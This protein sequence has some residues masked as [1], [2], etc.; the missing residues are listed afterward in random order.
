MGELTEQ[1]LPRDVGSTGAHGEWPIS[2]W[3]M[4]AR[5]AGTAESIVALIPERRATD[6]GVLVRTMLESMVTFAWIGIDSASHA[7]ARLR[8]D[9][10]Q[11]LK[12]D[13][14]V[15]AS[16]APALLEPETRDA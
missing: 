4:L 12:A 14:D 3:A 9:R 6:A 10:R 13:N 11:R 2:G 16:G 7:P 15:R 5:M 8:W 1:L